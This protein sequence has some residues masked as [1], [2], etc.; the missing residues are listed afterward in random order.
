VALVTGEDFSVRVRK[1]RGDESELGQR[2]LDQVKPL[3]KNNVDELCRWCAW[4]AE[5][6]P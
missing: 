4:N 3:G 2:Q 6:L 5:V 1:D